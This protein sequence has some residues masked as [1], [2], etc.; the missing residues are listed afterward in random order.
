MIALRHTYLFDVDDV[1]VFE[2]GIATWTKCAR[3]CVKS[4][5]SVEEVLSMFENPCPLTLCEITDKD[6]LLDYIRP[7]MLIELAGS[8]NVYS[9]VPTETGLV[10]AAKGW[11]RRTIKNAKI[12]LSEF[13]RDGV[14]RPYEGNYITCVLSIL[15]DLGE[16]PTRRTLYGKRMPK[17]VR[18]K[19]SGNV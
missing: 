3:D 13:S 8:T 15:S 1:I 16:K 6:N 12:P 4:F 18:E 2:N 17:N 14:W 10:L 5:H 9:V 7:G 19:E 11:T